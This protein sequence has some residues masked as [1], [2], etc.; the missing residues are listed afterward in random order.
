M[1]HLQS[2]DLKMNKL[3][4]LIGAV[5]KGPINSLIISGDPGIGKSWN[6]MK[7]LEEYEE[8]N[9]VVVN[10]VR[11]HI[12]PFQCYQTLLTYSSSN[13]ITVFDDSDGVFENNSS[14]NLLKAASETFNQ[15]K[16]SWISGAADIQEFFFEG[17]LLILTNVNFH[18]SIH[19]K[20]LLDRFHVYHL[21]ITLE[22][23]L[24]KIRD[25]AE[26]LM[27]REIAKEVVQFIFNNKE[28]LTTLTIRTFV[29]IAELA[30]A[31]PDDW[32]ELA[33]ST[34]VDN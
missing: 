19:Y 12:T 15:R 17:K 28:L 6:V 13:C 24:H 20:A 34:I 29:K 25:I 4:K 10:L 26:T 32:R 27:D 22:E 30:I 9:D 8:T 18:R 21:N 5:V 7:K 11:G 3:H 23:K 14:L 2:Y 31:L 1:N 16:L 33:Q